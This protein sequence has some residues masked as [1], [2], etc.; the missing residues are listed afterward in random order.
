MADRKEILSRFVV[1]GEL[2]TVRF[3]ESPSMDDLVSA[4]A[5]LQADSM[6]R[7]YSLTDHRVDRTL[8]DYFVRLGVER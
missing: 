6:D 5:R 4:E 3:I 7:S 2:S 8:R 1:S